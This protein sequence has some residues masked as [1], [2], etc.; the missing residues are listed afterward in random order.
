MATVTLPEELV[1]VEPVITE[2][3]LYEVIDGKVVEKPYMGTFQTEVAS[4]LTSHFDLHARQGGYG[5]VITEA[6]VR[7]DEKTQYRPDVAFVSFEKWPRRRRTPDGVPWEIIPDLAIEV[8]SKSDKAVEVLAKVRHYFQAGVRGVWLVYATLEVIHTYNS[9]DEI[10]VLTRDGVLDGGII[11]PG[12][13][14]P[15]AVLFEETD[16]EEDDEDPTD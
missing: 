8:V 10:R 13:Q 1:E 7:I 12:F 16:A 3:R 15:L 5:R 6:L 11:A 14:L 9:F 4:I 2:D